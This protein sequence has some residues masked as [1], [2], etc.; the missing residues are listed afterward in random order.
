MSFLPPLDNNWPVR[1]SPS[2][3]RRDRTL[4]RRSDRLE[5][6]MIALLVSAFVIV[7]P[8][9]GIAAG[10]WADARALAQVRADQS[11]RLVPATLAAGGRQR[12]IAFSPTWISLAA[13]AQWTQTGRAHAAWV[14][15]SYQAHPGQTVRVWVT[16]AGQP[17]PP[18]AGRPGL[19]LEVTLSAAGAVLGLALALSAIGLAA[20]WQLNRR[21]LAEWGRAWEAVAPHW[22]KYL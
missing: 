7:G 3:I 20:L 15:V 16:A 14:P 9:A 17:V 4:R 19:H 2:R 11:L 6:A 10:R 8:L 1:R 12:L 22:S 5:S 13:R 21:R 18:P